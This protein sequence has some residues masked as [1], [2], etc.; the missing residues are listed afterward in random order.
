MA[1]YRNIQMSF[2]TDAKI[3]DKFN[4]EEKFLYLYFL[5][6][7]HTNL[8]GCY[9]I[10][11]R[12]IAFET[13][14][15]P[16]KAEKVTDALQQKG[17]IAYS[18]DTAEILLVNW[19]RYNWTTSEKFRKPL[20][21]EIQ[22]IKAADFKEYLTNLFEYGDAEFKNDRVSEIEDRVSNKKKKDAQ[23][24]KWAFGENKNVYLTDE[25]YNK[26]IEKYGVE[27]T[28]AAIDKLDI[29]LIDPKNKN[30]Y[31][32]HYGALLRWVFKAV[33]E[34]RIRGRHNTTKTDVN[35]YLMAQATGG[36]DYGQTGNF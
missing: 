29:Y 8:C 6:N 31:K 35:D 14:M 10:S 26:L 3:T 15:T 33:E 5:T 30:K 34:D 9:E 13:G 4:V 16:E 11:N 22:M 19:Y 17:V 27:E 23:P 1:I 32:S 21:N 12:Q 25:E 20:G 2:W 18:K 24:E 36:M 28:S 7:P